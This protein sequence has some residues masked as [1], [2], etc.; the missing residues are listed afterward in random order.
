MAFHPNQRLAFVI[1]EQALTVTSYSYQAD[2]GTLTEIASVSTIPAEVVER[3]GFSTADIH[4]HPSG[5]WLYGS[6]RG[7]DSIVQFRIDEAT[8]RLTLVGHE[9]RTIKKPRNFHL[10]PTGQ[11]AL[12]ANQGG[13]SVS[14]FRI[15]PGTGRLELAGEPTPAG[16]KPSFVGVLPL[17]PR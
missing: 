16:A 15:D 11:L 9:Q 13:D 3:K 7:H 2:Q 17:A 5:K 6:N 4:V 10:D 12:V 8:G 1:N 14:I